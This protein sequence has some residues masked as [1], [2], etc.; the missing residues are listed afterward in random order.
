MI[1]FEVL[2]KSAHRVNVL[3]PNGKQDLDVSRLAHRCSKCDGKLA[4]FVEACFLLS[5]W[6]IEQPRACRRRRLNRPR[7]AHACLLSVVEGKPEWVA[8]SSKRPLGGVGLG[9]FQGI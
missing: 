5:S 1:L 2:V 4:R 3:L 6:R 8:K 9:A 7:L